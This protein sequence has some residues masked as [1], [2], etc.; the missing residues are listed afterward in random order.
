MVTEPVGI[1]VAGPRLVG[2]TDLEDGGIHIHRQRPVA[3]PGTGRPRPAE[4]LAGHLVELADVAEGEAAQPRP[5]GG[6]GH[7]PVAEHAG[8]R[9]ATQQLH[10]VDAVATRDQS[11]YQREQLAPRLGRPRPVTEVD[12]LVGGL[13]DP[14]PLRQRC[15]QQ[16]T[17][18]RDG[19]RI[20]EGDIDLVQHDVGGWHRKGVLRLGD[21]DRLAAVI[22]PGQRALFVI[23]PSPPHNRLGGSRLR[24]KGWRVLVRVG[25]CGQV[26]ARL[27]RGAVGSPVDQEL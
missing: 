19:P 11:M 2:A 21:H 25:S 16:Q 27:L 15:R 26:A 20:I 10:V 1:A 6:G 23:S 4:N 5:H 22:L 17:S 7:H 13:L 14:Q 8:G 9:P 24:R 12:E 18:M 3:G